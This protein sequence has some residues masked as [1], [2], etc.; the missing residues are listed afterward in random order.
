MRW[1]SGSIVPGLLTLAIVPW[2]LF[3]WVKP[4][5]RD[6]SGRTRSGAHGIGGMGPLS[7]EESGSS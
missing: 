4:E 2:L 3:R 6:T 1:F 5:I 7:R